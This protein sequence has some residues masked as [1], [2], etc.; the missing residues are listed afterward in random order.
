MK[1]FCPTRQKLKQSVLFWLALLAMRSAARAQSVEEP[2]WLS[3]R[4]TDCYLSFDGEA[5]Q[6]TYTSS[7]AASQLT[8]Q[9]LYLSPTLGLGLAGSIYHPD[10]FNFDLTGEPGYTRQDFITSANGSSSSTHEEDYLQN[11]R[12]IGTLFQIKPFITTVYAN[13]SYDISQYDF[14]NQAIVNSS[15]YGFTSGYQTGPVP[16][17]VSYRDSQQNS[18]SLAQNMETDEQDVDLHAHNDRKS[19]DYTDLDYRFSQIDQNLQNSGSTFQDNN[20][21]QYLTMMDM[22]YFG[23]GNRNTLNSMLDYNSVDSSGLNSETLDAQSDLNLYLTP[24]LQNNDTYSLAW[25]QDDTSQVIQ[26]LGRAALQHQLYDSLSTSIDVHGGLSEQSGLNGSELDAQTVGTQG[27]VNYSKLL[28]GWGHLSLGET[29]TYDLISQTSSGGGL[30]VPNEPLVLTALPT[31]LKLPQDLSII[32]VT[33]TNNLPL[34][35]GVDYSL[36]SN[37]NPW[38]LQIILSSPNVHSGDTVLVTYSVQSNPTGNYATFGDQFQIR[39]DL[40]NG[41]VGLYSS[42]SLVDNF[43][44]SPGFVLENISQFQA[45]ADFQWKGLHLG[46]S[47]TKQISSF[48]TSD[49]ESLAEGYSLPTIAHTTVSVNLDQ[50]WNDYVQQQERVSYYDFIARLEWRPFSR[51][52]CDLEGGVQNQ[53][54][55]VGLDQDMATARAHVDWGIGKTTLR[56]GYEYGSQNISG[57]WQETHFIFLHLRRNF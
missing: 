50:R 44:N 40:W 15:S 31:P 57:E 48:Y 4:L 43:T 24:H 9:R 55:G 54:G 32:S 47:Y 37:V 33:T 38:T 21:N 17:T 52:T 29:A 39:L 23:P 35:E 8:S 46:G 14:F 28:G 7:A 53:S 10:L 13:Q 22:E 36:N 16:V 2:R 27:S 5:E 42:Y 12:F 20:D 34:H 25:Y 19:G 41:L 30:I 11:Y 26:N 49:S 18:S 3:L 6:Q 51:L 45:G 1:R 56:L